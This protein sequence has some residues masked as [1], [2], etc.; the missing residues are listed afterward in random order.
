MRIEPLTR[1]FNYTTHW[2]GED[3]ETIASGFDAL[4]LAVQHLEVHYKKIATEAKAGPAPATKSFDKHHQ[5]ACGF[6]FVTS[7]TVDGQEQTFTYNQRLIESKLVF[8][9]T[10]NQPEPIK[11]IVKFARQYSEVSHRFLAS[12]DSAPALAQCIRLSTEW[13]AIVMA[14]SNYE[15]LDD[16]KLTKEEQKKVLEKVKEI[17]QILH[18][19]GPVHGDIRT[20]NILV[21][22]SSLASEEVKI[23][24][25]DFDWAG[26]IEEAKYPIGIN[27]E[28]EA[29][30][31]G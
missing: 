9:A 11:C 20:T 7:Y 17:V 16:L 21:D 31:G 24:F 29:S 2:L 27:R 6:P 19:Q 3:R 10:T 28:T 26:R 25:L 18:D 1:G 15:V 5:K 13:V 12:H 4:V 23:H 30:R 22:R 8:L 14:W